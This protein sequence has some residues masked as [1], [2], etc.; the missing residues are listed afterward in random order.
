M[1]NDEL[2]A[3]L[4]TLRNEVLTMRLER[5]GLLFALMAIIS[6]HP[7]HEDCQFLLDHYLNGHLEKSETGRSLPDGAKEHLRA[8]V[9]SLQDAASP[10]T[11][12]AVQALRSKLFPWE[13]DPP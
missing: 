6:T 11:P 13:S 12:E 4:N 9:R 3:K 2:A 10:H 7:R 8:Y 5:R 1:T